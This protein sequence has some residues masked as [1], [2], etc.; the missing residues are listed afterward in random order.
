VT[1]TAGAR[2]GPYEILSALGVGGMGDVYRARDTKLSRE[3]ALKVLPDTF[4]HD[5]ERLARFRREAQ[6]LASLSHPHIGAIYGLDEANGTHF[7]V[8]ELVDGESLDTR[9]ARGSIPVDEALAIAKQI[10]DALDAAHEA[11]IIHRDMKPANIAL[12]KDGNVKVLDFGLAKAT[13]ATSRA[14]IDLA[15]SP[16]ITTPAMM[17]GVG[18][19]VGTAAYMSPEQARGKPIDKRTDIWAFGCVLYEMLTGRRLFQGDT[20]SDMLAAVL[21]TEPVWDRVPARVRPLL[22]RCLVKNPRRRLR[23]IGDLDLSLDG[24]A[25][26]VS[27]RRPWLAWSVAAVLLVT[28][29]PIAL[30]HVREEPRLAEPMRFQI[31]PTVTLSASGVLAVSPDGRYLAFAALDADGVLRVFVRA[32]NSLEVRPL[33]GSEISTVAPPP[34]WSPDSRFIAFDAGGKLKKQ[35]VSG[36]PAQTLCDL[37][38]ITVGG[39]WNRQGDIILGNPSGGLLRVSEAGGTASPV[40]ALDPSHKESGHLLPSFLPDGRHFVYLRISA[41]SPETSGSYIGTLNA[42]PDEQSSQPLMPYAVGLTYAP[43]GDSGPG[44]LLFVREGTLLAQPFD[45]R[46]LALTGDPVPVAQQVGSYRDTGFFSTSSNGLLVYRTTDRD[47]Q[48]TWFD[49]QGTV[50][51]RAS[52]PGRFRGVALSPDGTRAVASRTNAQDAATADLWMLDLSAGSRG[53]RFT[54]SPGIA[55]FPVWSPDGRVVTFTLRGH[56]YQKLASGAKDEEVL[57]LE[58]GNLKHPTSWSPDGRVLLIAAADPISRWDLWVLPLRGDP[59]PV[60]FARTRFDEE[61]GRFARDGRW[62]AYVSNE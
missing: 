45:A 59:K 49:R 39:S 22:Q 16:T 5:P 12:T 2:L 58:R 31:P 1:L 20:V 48:V 14:S 8:L 15:N 38:G 44:R 30:L 3:V 60:P 17:T 29:A 18:M 23:D 54:S 28:L 42:K 4:T 19:I 10:A 46:K 37:P 21:T 32:M 57:Q 9:I 47:F 24:A 43:S 36:G 62:V 41:T 52:E 6:V 7:L 35:D 50:L 33:M 26:V 25:D 56:L 40:T 34:F 13:Q 55:E 53:T 51:G 27:K 61:Q 11:G